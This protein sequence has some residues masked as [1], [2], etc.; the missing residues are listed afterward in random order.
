MWVPW[1]ACWSVLC[2]GR[3]RKGYS[4]KS[5]CFWM[6]P[7]ALRFCRWW[8]WLLEPSIT[9]HEHP[10]LSITAHEH[11]RLSITAHEQPL[12]S[13]HSA[14]ALSKACTSSKARLVH[15]GLENAWNKLL[16]WRYSNCNACL[17]SN[18]LGHECSREGRNV[19]LGKNLRQE[20]HTWGKGHTT[21][22]HAPAIHL[23]SISMQDTPPPK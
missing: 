12:L 20:E 5:T 18:P 2:L 6:G 7:G 1:L 19:P 3:S 13:M 14:R 4:A 9:A 17:G 8:E 22:F 16:G 23:R 21:F 11:P 10:L 15:R